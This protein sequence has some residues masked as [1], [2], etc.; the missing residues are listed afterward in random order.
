MKEAVGWT[1][2]YLGNSFPEVLQWAGKE[3]KLIFPKER[4]DV[5]LS[6]TVWKEANITLK[7]QR[8]VRQHLLSLYGVWMTAP[9]KHIQQ[10]TD[11]FVHPVLGQATI[12]EVHT[13]YLTKSV[14]KVITNLLENE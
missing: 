11:H 4:M 6:A 1:I 7:V 14:L 13:S 10:L 9:E 5:I 8:V 3:L 12:S 2:A